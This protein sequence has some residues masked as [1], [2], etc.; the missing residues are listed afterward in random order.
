MLIPRSCIESVVWPAVPQP[1]GASLLALHF[2]LEQ[3]QWLPPEEI[4]ALQ[5]R[6]LAALLSHAVTSIPW[7]RDRYAAA[8]FD[9]RQPLTPEV[10]S[11]VPLLRRADIQT[12]FE[13]LKS[14]AVPKSHGKVHEQRTSGSTGSPIRT[15][16]TEVTRFFWS[17]FTLRDHLWHRRDLRAKLAS[18]RTDVKDGIVK[19][20]GPSTDT[21][22]TT[23]QCALLNIR[24][25]IDTQV[26]WLAEQDPEY[27]LSHPSNT[28]AVARRCAEQ[29][30]RLGRLREVRAFGEV[31]SDEVR[32]VC[33]EIWNV[34][35]TD[36][37]S[38]TETGYIALQCPEHEHYH[39]QSEGMLVE[40]LD[41]RGMPCAPGETGRVVITTL[42]NFAMPLIRYEI[43]DYAE[44][45]Q[46]CACG[47][48]LPVLTRIMGRQR[49]LLTLPDGR[50]HWP[51]F[52]AESWSHI[53][54]IR[55]VQL[56]QKSLE[57]ILVRMVADRRL[58]AQEVLAFTSVLQGKFGYPFQ[59]DF[60]YLER[61]ERKRNFKY[62]DFV[63]EVRPA[64]ASSA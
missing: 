28:V 37:Y 60:E 64:G 47:R 42:H 46:P 33:R 10:F 22:F 56:V 19:G 17:G 32:A 31:V 44:A 54:P 8:G 15:L 57:R 49:N 9:P 62:E 29:G 41:D 23:G 53:A 34:P 51:S 30:V 55:Q 39:V 24:A 27:L 3:T 58:S 36:M 5:Y 35:V 11:S 43:L 52:P 59:I 26:R 4:E 48:G 12:G 63:S 45:G 1:A 2:Q 14:S 7:Y 16:G 25:D 20:W 50:Q 38:A 40:V 21:I 18:I 6:Q 13:A 61:I